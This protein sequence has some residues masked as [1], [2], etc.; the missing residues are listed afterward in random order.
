MQPPPVITAPAIPG[1]RIPNY[2]NS[3][4]RAI[5]LIGLGASA[6]AVVNRVG[7]R[8]L[9]NVAIATRNAAAGW[10]TITGEAANR[11]LNMIVIVCREDDAHLFRPEA[12][13]PDL[14]VTFVVLRH[15]GERPAGHAQDIQHQMP[16][17]VERARA[18]AD[19]FVTTSD[20]DYVSELIDNLAS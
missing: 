15:D 12:G 4:R 3:A 13:R 20:P 10:Q 16:P 6:S 7:L 18:C 1:N 2:R 19:L 8:G 9:P 11:D 14:S 5:R 17:E